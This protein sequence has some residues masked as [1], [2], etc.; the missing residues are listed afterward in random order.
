M[1][2]AGAAHLPRGLYFVLFEQFDRSLQHLRRLATILHVLT[3]MLLDVFVYDT[4][5]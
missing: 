3:S 2:A 1:T 5:Y 4:V